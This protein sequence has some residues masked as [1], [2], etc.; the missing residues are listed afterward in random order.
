[1]PTEARRRLSELGE[2]GFLE[3][4]RRLSPAGRDVELGI[5]DDC[6]I[7]RSGRRRLLLTTDALVEGVHFRWDWDGAAGHGR[8]AF[9]VNASDI[10][11]MAGRPRFALLSL[12]VPRRASAAD[13]RGLVR[14]FSAAARAG[15]C[16]L[17]GGNL[18]AGP[19]WTVSVSLIGDAPN[20]PLRRDG[21]R[22]GD[23]LYVSGR[24][25]AAAYARE[26][27]LGRRR[28]RA[29]ETR[30]FRR[31]VPR[32]ALGAALS[33]RGAASAAIDVSDGLLQDLAHVCRA[34]GVAA[35][36]DVQRIP[37]AP[38]L[39]RLPAR[40]RRRLALQGGE[41]YELLFTVPPRSVRR[42]A[43]RAGVDVTAIGRIVAGSGVRVREEDGTVLVADTRGFDH[44]RR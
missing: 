3:G 10:A 28:G 24:I 31:P 43:A 38:A 35:I 5:G 36:V 33:R 22:P 8:R 16:A 15:G 23:L 40:E 21:A 42:V 26:I 39:R 32:L 41:D 12:I 27:L 17:V 1:L 30:A 19:C 13:L 11:A 29:S 37:Y 20:E 34:S 44:F 7:V 9:A 14:G 6:A 18:S 2:L 25:G 4:L